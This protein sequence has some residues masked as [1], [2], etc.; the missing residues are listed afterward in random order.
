MKSPCS[1]QSPVVLWLLPLIVS[2]YSFLWANAFSMSAQNPSTY[3]SARTTD[4]QWQ[5]HRNYAHSWKRLRVL[6]WN[7]ENLFDTLHDDGFHDEEFLPS[8]QRNWTSPRY[9]R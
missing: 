9:W 3:S 2:L 5:P 4:Q 7:V 6:T 8:S 1:S